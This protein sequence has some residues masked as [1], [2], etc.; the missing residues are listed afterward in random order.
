MY[1]QIVAGIDLSQTARI[2]TA[3]TADGAARA[4]APAETRALQGPAPEALLDVAEGKISISSWLETL[5]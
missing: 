5:V 1:R 2:A 3:R 4:G